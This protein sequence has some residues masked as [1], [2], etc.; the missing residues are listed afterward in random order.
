MLRTA[1][2]ALALAV[3]A[4]ACAP[5]RLPGTEILDTRDNRAVIDVVMRYREALER[6]DAPA[7][8]ALVAPRYFD[9]GGTPDPA[10]DLD[11]ARLEEALPGTLEKLEG[12]KVEFT[13]RRVD[14]KGDEATAEVLWDTWYRVTTPGGAVARRDSDLQRLRL[15]RVDGAW[16]L[17]GGL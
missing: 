3:A 11:R 16:K 14:V 2:A 17:A 15:A 7:V 5:K 1:L 12:A 8:L 4:T 6:R 13:L 10:D 9:D